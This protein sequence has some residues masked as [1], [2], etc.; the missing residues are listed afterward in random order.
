[1]S[2][3]APVIDFIREEIAAGSFLGACLLVHQQGQKVAEHFE[4]VYCS[5]TV[6]DNALGKD[7]SHMLYSFSKGVSATIVAIA[8]QKGL[9]DYDAPLHAY[10][11]GYRGGWKSETT[12]RHLLNHTAGIPNCNLNSVYT[13][14]LWAAALQTCCEAAVEWKPGSRS[15]YHAK[16]AMFLA[17]E[18]VRSQ[19][20]GRPSWERICRD[21]LLDPIGAKTMTFQ[22]PVDE[23]IALTPQPAELPWALTPA[24]FPHLGHAGGG[25]FGRLEDIIKVLQLHLNGGTWNGRVILEREQLEEMHRVRHKAEILEAHAQ[26]RTPGYESYGLGW[27]IK[28]NQK[29]DGF[30]LGNR[31]LEGTFGHAGIWTVMGVGIPQKQRAIA[32]IST[33]PIS[34]LL[35]LE[36][37]RNGIT[38]LINDVEV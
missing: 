27:R 35:E 2:P 28:L 3:Y 30:G 37:I 22:I 29:N 26:N 20:P 8:R 9:I 15:E 6:R 17:A 5:D 25:I 33:H 4:G 10:I 31:T 18:A 32:F 14:D 19:V 16:S 1:M 7:V 34:T 24:H 38:D 36:R 21:W 13:E 23:P 12:I 11:P